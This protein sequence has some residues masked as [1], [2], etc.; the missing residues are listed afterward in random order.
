MHTPSQYSNTFRF[1]F[2]WI[3][4]L[5]RLPCVWPKIHNETMTSYN[6]GP[7]RC[8]TF[9]SST[10]LIFLKFLQNKHKNV[11]Q[12]SAQH[13]FLLTPGYRGPYLWNYFD[14][15]RACE[16]R[17]VIN[18]IK[19]ETTQVENRASLHAEP[20]FWSFRWRSTQKIFIFNIFILNQRKNFVKYGLHSSGASRLIDNNSSANLAF[21]LRIC[22]R[23]SASLTAA[24]IDR[25]FDEMENESEPK[26][27]KHTIL[28]FLVDI[29]MINTFAFALTAK[30]F[31]F[32]SKHSRYIFIFSHSQTHTQ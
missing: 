19:I 32:V 16:C 25:D 6:W 23:H 9:L 28:L 29:N 24:V 18:W 21:Y 13:H 5:H 26:N 14:G 20:W 4:T 12:I 1:R 17:I 11:F 2:C 31:Y 30:T 7:M 3:R 22:V 8:S 15:C 27:A 10:I